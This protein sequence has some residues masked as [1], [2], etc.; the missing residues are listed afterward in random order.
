MNEPDFKQIVMDAGIPTTEAEMRAEW[1][2]DVAA[3]GYT[4]TS[5]FSPVWKLITALIIRPPLMLVSVMISKVLPQSF[6]KSASGLMVDVFAW[7]VE[8]ER[9]LAS[10]A[11]GGITFYRVDASASVT[12]P[13]GKQIHSPAINGVSY[14]LRTTATATL[15]VGQLEINITVEADNKGSH[16]NLPDGFYSILKQPISGVSV[17]NR[18]GWLL[19]PGADEEEDDDLKD[20]VRNQFSAVNQWHTDAVYTAIISNFA[21]IH[22]RTIFFEG[23]APRGPGTANAYILLSTGNPSAGFL[24][25]IQ[26]EI[27]TNGNHGHGDDLQVFAMPETFHDINASLYFVDGLTIEQ[28]ANITSDVNAFIRAAFRENETYTPTLT[29]PESRF[30][31]SRLAKELHERFAEIDSISFSNS[32]ITSLMN[33]PRINNLTVTVLS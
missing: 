3:A 22:P 12:I 14:I 28:R 11:R 17:A 7:G 1:E 15:E 23:N 27:S 2:A 20:R 18:A 21:G 30:S 6:L 4:N 13:I 26:T 24:A 32:D 29:Q 25:D 33:V 31:F 5:E 8:L 19:A 10:K 16:Y 9:K